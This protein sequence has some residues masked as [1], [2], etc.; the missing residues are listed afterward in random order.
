MAGRARLRSHWRSTVLLTVV[1]AVGFGVALTAFAGARRA[2]TAM[3]DFVSYVRPDTG[4]VFFGATPFA[5]PPVAGPAAYSEGV[6][7]YARAV[8]RL[9][10]IETFYR[11]LYLFLSTDP[12]GRNAGDVNVFGSPDA[13]LFHAM[14]RP[15]VVAGRLAG[16]HSSTEVVIN[17]FAA[18]QQHLH[19]GSTLRLHAPAAS[20]FQSGGGLLNV[21]PGSPLGPSFLVR[22]VGIIRLPTDVNAILPIA[23]KQNVSYEGQQNIYVGPGFVVRMADALGLPVQQLPVMNVFNVSLR[24]GVAQWPAFAAAVRATGTGDANIPVNVAG[25]DNRGDNFGIEQAAQS[26]QRG[27]GLEVTALL[28]FGGLAALVT[29]LLVGQVAARQLTLDRPDYT[30]M[31]VVGATRPQL[32]AVALTRTS[33]VAV[34]GGGMAV[35]IAA[36]AS[37][38]MP[39]GL[40]GQA[41]IRPGFDVDVAVL[42]GGCAALVLLLVTRV[43]VSAW[44][45]SAA[46]REDVPPGVSWAGRAL[47]RAR[48]PSTLSLG[49]RFATS[50]GR[51]P[52]AVPVASAV[53]ATVVAV[54]GVTAALTFGTSLSH[55]VRTPSQQ[56]WTWD[57]LVGNPNDV[58]D[59]VAT[60]GALLG[61]NR[62]VGAYAG[63]ANLGALTVDR[64][65][66]PTV[67]AID[68]LHGSIGPP[69]LQG[70]APTSPDEVA[71]AT[72]TLDKLHKHVGQ[73]VSFV[74]PN[75]P[76]HMHVVGRMTMPSVGDMMPNGL[77][78]GAW[79]SGAF[80]HK[81]WMSP[82]NPSG[83]PPQGTDVF[84]LFAVDFQT[85]ASHSAALAS[86][87][88]DFGGSV[89]QHLPAEDVVNLQSVAA[90]PLILAGLVGVLGFATVGNILVM[91]V[92][93]RR[94]DLAVLKT[95]GFLRTQV[96]ATVAW[97]ATTFIVIAL[98][99]G[100]PLGI[101][102]GRWAWNAVASGIDSVSPPFVPAVAVLLVVPTALILGN[103]C[104]AW[105]G[106]RAGRV[107]PAEAIRA[108]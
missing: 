67:I 99:L 63:V 9:P 69:L 70:R 59:Q 66:V 89:L 35:G 42:V 72:R 73:T 101:A 50:S 27:I 57:A 30:V 53:F 5:P 38:L 29:V 105:P 60:D 4:T 22:V 75:G 41:E 36:L 8:M 98:A 28:I 16:P 48:L 47:D 82:D 21:G 58:S 10:Q 76:V 12:H 3:P 13:T 88:R 77:G 85:G 93:R 54:A 102:G 94:R 33:F 44:R 103:L 46:R 97:Q 15:M 14:D 55:L 31:Q 71:L 43:A 81:Q 108:G 65:S 25:G 39:F 32:L 104:A 45:M 7:P 26:A 52:H 74:S 91:S 78:E 23:A 20:V 49:V 18:A 34:L 1:T 6:P 95:L 87:H 80:V 37:P 2:N 96:T 107:A 100:L 86:L 90:L 51:G 84:D 19:V 17:E 83:T 61:N 62:L 68:E 106:W 24:H 11:K 56:G 64:V 40:A 79:V 92:R